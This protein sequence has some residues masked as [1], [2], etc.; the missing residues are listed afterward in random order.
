M[1]D[2]F[3]F[4]LCCSFAQLAIYV[5]INHNGMLLNFTVPA[6]NY[7]FRQPFEVITGNDDTNFFPIHKPL[8]SCVVCMASF[9]T[10]IAWLLFFGN[11][12]WTVCFA[13]LVVAGINKMLCAILEKNTEYGC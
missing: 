8:Y 9:W 3:V 7:V 11:L 4:C 1:N 6:L 12:N 10:V 2:L 13:I 5:S